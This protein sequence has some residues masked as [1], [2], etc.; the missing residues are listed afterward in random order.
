M[1][2]ICQRLATNSEL[3]HATAPR[4][5]ANSRGLATARS[6]TT[7]YPR[8]PEDREPKRT[9]SQGLEPP[10]R[11]RAPEPPTASTGRVLVSRTA[12]SARQGQGEPRGEGRPEEVTERRALSGAKSPGADR[13]I[14]PVRRCIT[15][16]GPAP[17]QM[18]ADCCCRCGDLGRSCH[19]SARARSPA[20]RDREHRRVPPGPPF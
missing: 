15:S 8:T 4:A 17:R 14:A 10:D 2:E 1:H 7:K 20:R 6:G 18:V 9:G 12:T 11:P 13:E 16:A 5:N 19:G 3:R